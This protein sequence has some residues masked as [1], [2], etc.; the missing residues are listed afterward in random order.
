[1]IFF[2][3]QGSL[4][5]GN[6]TRGNDIVKILPLPLRGILSALRLPGSWP[7]HLPLFFLADQGLDV[8][9][10]RRRCGSVMIDGEKLQG[11]LKYFISNM[12]D[13]DDGR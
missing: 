8:E 4:I 10:P 1:M 2:H 3:S 5:Q 6:N 13:E 11:Q 9:P 7:R 12:P